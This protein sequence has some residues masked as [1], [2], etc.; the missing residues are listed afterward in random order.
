MNNQELEKRL[1][2]IFS[3]TNFFDMIEAADEF[4]KDYIKTDFYKK[5]KL[6]FEE[7]LKL[8]KVYYALQLDDL[9]EKLQNKVN[10]FDLSNLEQLFQQIDTIYANENAE[11]VEA[12]KTLKELIK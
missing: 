2:E 10:N 1:K 9:A 4:K 12:V 7:M 3:I 11:T 8:S 6:P 5:T